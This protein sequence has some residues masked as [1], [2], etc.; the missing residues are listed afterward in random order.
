MRLDPAKQFETLKALTGIDTTDIETKRKAMFEER[1]IVNRELKSIESRYNAIVVPLDVPE[2]EISSIEIVDKITKANDIKNNQ[3]KAVEKNKR[4]T[5]DIGRGSEKIASLKEEIKKCEEA[6]KNLE[7]LRDQNLPLTK[8]EIPNT[9]ALQVEL[10]SVDARN[11]A[12]QLKQNKDKLQK[13]LNEQKKKSE[14][15]TVNIEKLDQ[16]KLT[17][18]ASAKFPVEG[19]AF[20]EELITYGGLPL[21]QASDAEKL[22]VSM[23]MAMAMNPKLR[24]LRITDGSLLD[25]NSMK[26]IEEMAKT[27][28]YQVW[29]E[30]V[31]ESGKIGIVIE[32]GAVIKNNELFKGESNG[33]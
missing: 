12:F 4:L 17:R 3:E 30:V 28:D 23:A 26:I 25:S 1:T 9:E 5:E 29:V 33:K 15:L 13:E 11:K 20:G 16:E 6:I 24:V 7:V 18:V 14:N 19:L 22:R 27:N 10:A 31:D 8:V 2:K 21:D 32:D